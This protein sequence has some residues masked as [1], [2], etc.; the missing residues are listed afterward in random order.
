LKIL[1]PRPLSGPPGQAPSKNARNLNE[2][3]CQVE[4]ERGNHKG[5]AEASKQGPEIFSRPTHPVLADKTE[6]FGGAGT[7]TYKQEPA[8]PS[9]HAEL[10][11]HD[12]V[13]LSKQQHN[14]FL[15]ARG[16]P[17]R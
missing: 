5:K 8:S 15:P 10:A 17:P 7:Q 6:P 16:P 13:A 12:G 11:R 14:H 1:H 3:V 4:R 9:F 2:W